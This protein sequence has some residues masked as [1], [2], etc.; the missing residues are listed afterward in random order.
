MCLLR[1]PPISRMPGGNVK[2]HIASNEMYWERGG[3]HTSYR[4]EATPAARARLCYCRSLLSKPDSCSLL[5]GLLLQLHLPARRCRAG[6]RVSATD[7]TVVAGRSMMHMPQQ[8]DRLFHG[9]VV[10]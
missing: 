4:P 8:M 6:S 7:L 5:N 2:L 3:G 1:F 10:V 9:P